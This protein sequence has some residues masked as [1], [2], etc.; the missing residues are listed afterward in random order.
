MEEKVSMVGETVAMDAVIIQEGCQEGNQ[1][2]KR[3]YYCNSN[4]NK[5]ERKSKSRRPPI[6]EPALQDDH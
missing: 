1:R 3:H 6:I 4:R 5:N 2:A